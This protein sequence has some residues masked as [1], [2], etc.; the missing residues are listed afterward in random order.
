MQTQCPH[1]DTTFRITAQQC[2]AAQ[3]LVRCSH[4][5]Q[6]FNALEHLSDVPADFK[7]PTVQKTAQLQQSLEHSLDTSERSLDE[8]TASV[9]GDEYEQ[10]YDDE[11]IPD[12][13]EQDAHQKRSL[14]GLLFWMLLVFLGLGILA[15]QYIWWAQRDWALQHPELRPALISACEWLECTLPTTRNLDSFKVQRH[16]IR[17]HPTLPNAIQF[18]ATFVNTAIFPQPY[19]DIQ[20]T[21]ENVGAQPLARRRFKPSEYLHTQKPDAELAAGASVHLRLE[22]VDMG[23]VIESGRVME[24]YHFE[25]F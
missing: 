3:G 12:L 17:P 20:L 9:L 7:L 19:P 1:C 10:E 5:T 14:L 18:D 16:I 8:D 4:C 23:A 11:D 6:V 2:Q 25:F 24:G 13:F 21:F 22:L 15:G